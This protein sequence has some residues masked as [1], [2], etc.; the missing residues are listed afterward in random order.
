MVNTILRAGVFSVVQ[1]AIGFGSYWFGTVVQRRI[2]GVQSRPS[3]LSTLGGFAV[4]GVVFAAGTG[5]N[6]FI[7][8]RPLIVRLRQMPVTNQ[9]MLSGPPTG[10]IG[11]GATLIS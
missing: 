3:F 11:R 5:V 8:A 4:T 10:K 2:D 7:Q 1:A 6:L 9:A